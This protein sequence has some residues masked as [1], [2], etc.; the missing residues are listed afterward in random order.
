MGFFSKVFNS[1][2][3]DEYAFERMRG[4]SSLGLSHSGQ[5]DLY[6]IYGYKLN[7]QFIDYYGIYKRNGIA[8]RVV[9][10][11]P[12]ACWSKMPD[13]T[14][15]AETEDLT[16]FEQAVQK[17]FKELSVLQ[18]LN[19]L[20]KLQRVGRYGVLLFGGHIDLHLPSKKI[21]KI[22][23]VAPYSEGSVL[24]TNSIN[25]IFNYNYGKPELYTITTG[26]EIT[27]TKSITVHHSQVI[28]IAENAFDNDI[29]GG[30]CLEPILNYLYDMDKVV[31]GGAES[32]F[33]N[34]RGG[35]HVN[36]TAAV[37][38][39]DKT[40]I[41]VKFNQYINKFS[42]ILATVNMDVKPLDYA[43][44]QP[45]KHFD[46]ILSS[47]AGA[48]GIPKAILTGN[49]VGVRASS[50]DVGNFF[51]QIESRQKNFC[52]PYILRPFIDKCIAWGALPK[53]INDEY[54]IKWQPLINPNETEKA[55]VALKKMQA[56]NAYTT[57]LARDIL[58]PQ[59]AGE[60]IG[61]DY[62]EDDL[63]G[64]DEETDDIL[65]SGDLSE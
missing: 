43:V 50:Q 52:E 5:R 65:K 3:A 53:P 4:L 15:D 21:N 22:S 40:G 6:E 42:R 9:N 20:D 26:N 7:P 36:S 8:R 23:Y 39:E 31:G 33:L 24:I 44:H 57:G 56:I 59:Q 29:V 62:R 11:Y 49:E 48:T 18:Q 13:I 47:I 30:S 12:D 17:L 46:I 54:E 25:D 34:S 19:R 10:A 37:H 28:H 51:L 58:T 45:D 41:A 14:D 16:E 63:K 32:F 2:T 38:G 55:D 60:M 61:F 27:G 1:K 64:L 35:L